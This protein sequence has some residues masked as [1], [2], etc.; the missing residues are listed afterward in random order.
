MTTLRDILLNKPLARDGARLWYNEDESK[1]KRR[2]A[3]K[4]TDEYLAQETYMALLNEGWLP[5]R[6]DDLPVMQHFAEWLRGYHRQDAPDRDQLR[7]D[8]FVFCE[9]E[10]IPNNKR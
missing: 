5:V 7:K 8:W 4:L 2:L 10:D 6:A 3:L 1:E 9:Q